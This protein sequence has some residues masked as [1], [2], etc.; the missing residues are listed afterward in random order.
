MFCVDDGNSGGEC[1]SLVCSD[2]ESR[3]TICTDNVSDGSANSLIAN[4][5]GYG[6]SG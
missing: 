1:S 6:F 2:A 4:L 3:T 5:E